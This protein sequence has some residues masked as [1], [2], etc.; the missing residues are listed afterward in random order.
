MGCLVGCKGVW[1]GDGDN[2]VERVCRRDKYR[3]RCDFRVCKGE[4]Y[5]LKRREA[6]LKSSLL[7]LLSLLITHIDF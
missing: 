2:R 6:K 5:G 4:D 7:L 1:K 3:V